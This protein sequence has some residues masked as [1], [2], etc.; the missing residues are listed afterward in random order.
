MKKLLVL[1]LTICMVFSAA[2]VVPAG[3]EA[4]PNPL[5]IPYDVQLDIYNAYVSYSYAEYV[6]SATEHGFTIVTLEEYLS[7]NDMETLEDITYFSCIAKDESCY[8]MYIYSGPAGVVSPGLGYERLGPYLFNIA[9][10]GG[11]GCVC[12]Y[13]TTGD[14]DEWVI[15]T[16]G[17]AVEGSLGMERY[18]QLLSDRVVELAPFVYR[19]GDIDS[20]GTVTVSDVVLLR[21]ELVRGNLDYR[22]D[23]NADWE[24]TVSDV[25]ALRAVIVG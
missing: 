20:D 1:F 14:Q 4:V 11:T 15:E 2:A 24:V 25:V 17:S 7:I 13:Y 9:F 18:E 21:S 5:D 22:Y 6:R 3:A 23:I 8:I 10:Y 19:V 16:I 12:A